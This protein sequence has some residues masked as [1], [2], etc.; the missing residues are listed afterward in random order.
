MSLI[1]SAYAVGDK[2]KYK[3]RDKYYCVNNIVTIETGFIVS[4]DAR[5]RI[6]RDGSLFEWLRYKLRADSPYK[7]K[8]DYTNDL[9]IIGEAE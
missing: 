7:G 1:N 4:I 9:N 8:I 2:I 6:E 3:K 5:V